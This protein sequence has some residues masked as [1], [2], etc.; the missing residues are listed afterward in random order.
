MSEKICTEITQAVEGAI[1]GSRVTVQGS[2]GHYTIEVVAAAFEG[3]SRV[4]KQRMVL[5]PIAHLMKGDGA[6]VHAVDSIKTIT[7]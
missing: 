5:M 6:P 3:K 4:A 7:G 2:G 1:E